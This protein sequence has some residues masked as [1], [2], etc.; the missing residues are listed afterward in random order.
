MGGIKNSAG[1]P[2][3]SAARDFQPGQELG[4]WRLELLWCLVFGV[5]CLAIAV[6]S[7][8]MEFH[9]R[10]SCGRIIFGL[11]HGSK[12]V[13]D[14]GQVRIRDGTWRL[15][16]TLWKSIISACLRSWPVL[17]IRWWAAGA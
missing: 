9:P 5:W 8:G 6:W 14:L 4:F 7:F 1:G 2:V 11:L 3:R 13:F 16:A 17:S 10:A 15:P 12:L